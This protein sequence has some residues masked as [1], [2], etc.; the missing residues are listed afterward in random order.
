MDLPHLSLIKVD[1]NP[2]CFGCGKANPH[3]L[4]MEFD[5]NSKTARAE[6]IPTEYHQGWPGHVHG[7]A[8]TAAI[9]EAIGWATFLNNIYAVTAKLDVR[10]KSMAR[11]GETLIVTAN[12]IKES[13]RI[14]EI[15]AQVKRED[16]TIV[17]EASSLQFVVQIR[18][19]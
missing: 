9:D 7:G 4:K 16:G 3:G 2:L 8:L 17:A 15:E 5:R 13:T 12:V 11:V 14:L 6:F 19:P 10:F 18:S 1:E